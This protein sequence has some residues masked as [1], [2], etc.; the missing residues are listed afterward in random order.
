MNIGFE[1]KRLF[2]NF[3]GLGNYART[4]V[5][6]LHQYYPEHNYHLFTP[7]IK[8]NPRIK[9]FLSNHF[10]IHKPN[11][12]SIIWRNFFM[13]Q[14]IHKASIDLFHGLSA[15][16]PRNLTIPT[17]VTIHDLIFES[18]PEQYNPI[19]VK[20]YRWKA[21]HACHVANKVIAISEATK[22]DII[23][24]YSIPEEK[25]EILYQGCDDSFHQFISE[26]QLVEVRE[27]YALPKHYLLYVG[28]VIPRKNLD[29]IVEAFRLNNIEDLH[30]VCI[31][32]M[33]NDYAQQIKHKVN[34]HPFL[35][36]HV[37]F[38]EQVP[39]ADFPAIYKG[40][41]LFLYPSDYEG[42]GIPVI[43]AQAV[44]TPVITSHLSSLRE[45]GGSHSCLLHEVSS[46]SIA[47]AIKE[48]IDN[49]TKQQEMNM[50][51]K[52]YIKKFEKRKLSE[53]LMQIYSS[54][55]A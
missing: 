50:K 42:F 1:S 16:L 29:K 44:G 13:H 32:S 25:I 49:T 19:D 5:H 51:G 45:A 30:L 35:Q 15:E 47:Q 6:N 18:H 28:S 20:I 46:N 26:H 38:L 9:P 12:F 14:S 31:G 43:E 39:F 27:T 7:S 10:H 54:I 21:K 4:L 48:L 8:D 11:H 41:K 23:K 3:T 36:R 22:Q 52:E 34:E 53:Q 2:C 33:K 55:L 17:V 40:A 37:H 24:Y